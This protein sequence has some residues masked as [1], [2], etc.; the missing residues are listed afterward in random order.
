MTEK[1]EGLTQKIID[2]HAE[3][4]RL[5]QLAQ[6]LQDNLEHF[7]NAHQQLRQNQMLAREKERQSLQQEIRRLEK[8]L[9]EETHWRQQAEQTTQGLHE[10]KTTLSTQISQLLHEQQQAGADTEQS[11]GDSALGS[12]NID[13]GEDRDAAG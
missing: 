6:R 2:Q 3:N 11:A 10:E 7:E 1:T 9:A 5:H 12:G 8:I 13:T 4:A